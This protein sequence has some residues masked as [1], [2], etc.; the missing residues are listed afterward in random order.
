M[1]MD[2]IEKAAHVNASDIHLT[3]DSKPLFRIN[4]ELQA[5]EEFPK[6][7]DEVIKENL[8]DILT[9]EQFS[10]LERDRQIDLATDTPWKRCRF[11]IFSQKGHFDLA[12]RL[13]DYNIRSVDD[14]GLPEGIKSLASI[15]TGLILVTGVTGSGKSTTLASMIDYINTYYTKNI[16]TLEDPIEFIHN[17]KMS[18]VRQR[19]LSSD[20]RS[21]SDGLR[22][23]LREDPDVVLVGEMRT[24]EE[25]ASAI[26]FAETGH[27][28]MSTMHTRN[29]P[30]TIDRIIDVFPPE[31]QVQIRSQL[32]NVLEGIISQILIPKK[33][34][35]RTVCAE[36]MRANVP[37]RNMIKTRDNIS[38]IRDEIFLN[39]S[40]LGTQTMTQGLVEL[41]AKGVIDK[42]VGIRFS[43]GEELFN[44]LLLR[45]WVT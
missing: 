31:Q 4:G 13:I 1:L 11:N 28:V 42:D 41:Y 33:S 35:G 9:E 36:I 39:K 43:E 5:Q 27:L 20:V 18:I 10:T 12:I 44:K 22:A 7:T 37:I 34:G 40:K 24:P 16:I 14:L 23:S 17:R 26:T 8:T 6:V 2:V 32:S 3:Y 29:A 30:E 15:N 45:G 21:F 19:E 38:K 25:I